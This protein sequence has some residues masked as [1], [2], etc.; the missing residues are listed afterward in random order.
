MF[1]RRDNSLGLTEIALQ[2]LDEAKVFRSPIVTQV[3]PL[4][5]FYPAEEHHQNF[6]NR[7]PQNPYVRG[8]AIPKVEKVKQ[9]VPELA[10]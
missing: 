9:K 2:Q 7:N 5:S 10:K 6:C 3:V 4:Q 8:V 1:T